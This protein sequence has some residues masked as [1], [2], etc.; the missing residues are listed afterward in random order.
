[1]KSTVHLRQGLLVLS[2]GLAGLP[3]A[4]TDDCDAPLNR[5]QSRD[6]VRQ[7][8]A[9]QGWQIQRLK[10][11]D[12][13]YE[14]RGTDAQGRSFKAKIDPETLKV[15]KLKQDDHQRDRDRDR[16]A[17]ASQP[18]RP[19]QADGATP[20]SPLPPPGSAPRGQIE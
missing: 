4:A 15:L 5:W 20:S 13:C 6:A 11:D 9:A 7:M 10:I 17:K 12:G 3:A 16:D 8:A 2:L 14:V 1:M 19:A 18:V